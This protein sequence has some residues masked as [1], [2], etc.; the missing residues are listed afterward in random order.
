MPA[1][2][3]PQKLHTFEYQPTWEGKRLKQVILEVF[4]GIGSRSA[5]LCITNGLVAAKG[6]AP[7][8]DADAM[9]PEGAVL[10]VDLRHGVH[11]EGK[12]RHRALV[13]QFTVHHDDEHCV[14]VAKKAHVLVQPTDDDT[15]DRGVHGSAS[16]VELLKHYWKANGKAVINPI[17]VQRLDLQT[18]GLLVVAKTADAS[19]HLQRQ[20]KPPRSMKREYLAIVAGEFVTDAGT[21]KTEIGRG[22]TGLRQSLAAAGGRVPAGTKT[23]TA[24]T[25]YRVVRRLEKATLL[26]L[27]LET[28]RT[29]QIR[30]HCAESG[31]PVLGDHLYERL[32]EN[33]LERGARQM[34]GEKGVEHPYHE[35]MQLVARG[36]IAVGKPGQEIRRVAL[37]ATRLSFI[38]PATGER[39]SF[40]E[41]LPGD[42]ASAVKRL[43]APG[44]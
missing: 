26:E 2:S 41:P 3:I 30:I 31:H 14:V 38:H 19:R 12:A 16:L 9:I 36:H 28:G 29:H 5:L 8:R 4:P 18:S 15:L 44:G 40:E 11:G 43:R 32:G 42:L 10:Y 13:D 39:L 34:L 33:T 27:K 35:A 22:R 7:M 25:H 20:L 1:S 21:W 6:G 24:I 17:L 23:E 37:H